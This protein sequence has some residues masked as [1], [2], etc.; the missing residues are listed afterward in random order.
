MSR[1]SR[2]LILV[3]IVV[4]I[5]ACSSKTDISNKK[6]EKKQEQKVFKKLAYKEMNNENFF[7]IQAL[8]LENQRYFNQAKNIYKELFINTNKYEYLLKVLSL[9]LLLGENINLD[10]NVKNHIEKIQDIKEEEAILKLYIFSL[11]KQKKYEEALPI[12]KRLIEISKSNLNYALLGNIYL[13]LTNHKKAYKYIQK[14][15]ILK[16]TQANTIS[17]AHMDY[18]HFN[19]KEKAKRLL[20]EYIDEHTYVFPICFKL[21]SFYELEENKKDFL[22]LVNNMYKFY[23]KNQQK[24]LKLKS[25]QLLISYYI[26]EKQYRKAINFLEKNNPTNPF[27]IDLYRNTRENKKLISFLKEAYNRSKNEVFLAQLAVF[28]FE[29]EKDKK[30]ILDN[31]IKKLNNFVKKIDNPMYQNYLAYIL[32]DFDKDVKKGLILVKK[33][34]EKEPNNIAYI[35]TLAWGQFKIKDCKNAIKNMKKIINKAPNEKE[36]QDHWQIIKKECK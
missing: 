28:E 35:D 15:N 1:Y 4:L 27:L 8:E 36:I 7:I 21:L 31:V 9:N 11:V 3:F 14:A 18:F 34:L 22:L 6:I 33:A 12:A 5:S 2:N 24:T 32:I 30:A 19:K 16:T 25:E 23:D 10:K 20:K 17:L 29:N 26:K 13:D